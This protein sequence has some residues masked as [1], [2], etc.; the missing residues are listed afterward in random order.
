[1]STVLRAAKIN[2][3]GMLVGVFLQ[4]CGLTNKGIAFDKTL[5][6]YTL[7]ILLFVDA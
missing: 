6:H 3:Y 2:T 7:P 5:Q 4:D 1:M